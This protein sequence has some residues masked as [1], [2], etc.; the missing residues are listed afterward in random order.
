[1]SNERSLK[2]LLFSRQQPLFEDALRSTNHIVSSSVRLQ[3][4]TAVTGGS[5]RIVQSLMQQY[6]LG[7]DFA[8]HRDSQEHPLTAILLADRR[9][10]LFAMQTAMVKF[11]IDQGCAL[12]SPD[13][14]GMIPADYAM[15]SDN[16]T[17]ALALVRATIIEGGQK[18]MEQ[19]HI[20]NVFDYFMTLDGDAPR[21]RAHRIFLHNHEYISNHFKQVLQNERDPVLSQNMTGGQKAYWNKPL[22][23]A[24]QG[25]PHPAILY[26]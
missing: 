4:Q 26:Y 13:D 1:M 17:A 16:A 21:R 6:N 12:R 20:P 10:Y 11:L 3:W 24:Y 25:M 9:P 8:V 14:Y 2:D 22:K 5:I 19:G 23:V 7:P 18:Q 15:V